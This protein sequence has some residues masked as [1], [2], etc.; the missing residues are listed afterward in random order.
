MP[1]ALAASFALAVVIVI[2]VFLVV[3]T[4]NDVVAL[5]QRIDKAWANIDV[6]LKQRHDEIGRASCRE[7]VSSVV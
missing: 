5:I 6:A 1:F 7:R 2:V 4:Y 3:A